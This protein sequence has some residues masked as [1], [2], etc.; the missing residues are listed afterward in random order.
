MHKILF[1]VWLLLPLALM[2]QSTGSWEIRKSLTLDSLGACQGITKIGQTYYLYGDRECGIIR[3]YQKVGDTFI[4]SRPEVRLTI[5]D[6]DFINHPT[7][8][9][10]REGYPVFIGNSIRLNKEGTLW[11]AVIANVDWQGLLKSGTLDG[12]LFGT[13]EDDVCIQ[14][15]R[16]EYVRIG[17]KWWVATADY[18]PGPNEVRLYHPRRLAS[19]K[20]TSDKGVLKFKFSCTPW[21]QNLHWIDEKGL[22]VLIQNQIEG[23]RWRF[24]IVDLQAS[25]KRKQAVVTATYDLDRNDEL[26]GFTLTSMP[27]E[28]IGVSSS[29]RANVNIMSVFFNHNQGK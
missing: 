28:A 25:V 19:S 5:N 20:R 11:K 6:S 17:N 27:E 15:T 16:P 23:R 10:Y 13:I 12:H 26:E 22:L 1:L 18:G 24:T 9:A 21:V 8:I 4:L 14:G 2:S 29:R 3:A 7:G